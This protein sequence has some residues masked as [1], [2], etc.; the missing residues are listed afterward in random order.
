VAFCTYCGREISDQALTC[1]NCGH[2]N[3]ARTAIPEVEFTSAD[4]NA[5]REYAG[6][7]IRF[8]S[9]L[10]DLII[11]G[12]ISALLSFVHVGSVRTG[13]LHVGDRDFIIVFNPFRIVV[14]L[15]YGWLLIALAHGQTV[16]MKALAL[17]ITRPNGEP[18]GLGRSAARAAM[19]IISAAPLT[20]G[21]LWALWDPEKRTWHDM[22]ADTRVFKIRR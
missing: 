16:G 12:V 5:V 21:Y 6:F 3:E 14:V 8:G 7:W 4:P 20:L 22:V 9:L 1:P 17:R 2:P 18:V 19:T 10:I 13:P 11:V 15:G